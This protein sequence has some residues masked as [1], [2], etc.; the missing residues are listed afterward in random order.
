MLMLQKH[1]RY[2]HETG[3]HQGATPL[4]LVTRRPDF[5]DAMFE[6]LQ[7][8]QMMDQFKRGK[9]DV[10]GS[11]EALCPG[12]RGSKAQWARGSGHHTP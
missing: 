7:S 12:A 9:Y 5:A 2:D 4:F 3:F 1:V 10:N 8:I 11:G 6:A